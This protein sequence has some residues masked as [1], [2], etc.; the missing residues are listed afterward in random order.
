M[1]S[2]L[3]KYATN[4]EVYSVGSTGLIGKSVSV[5]LDDDVEAVRFFFLLN[6]I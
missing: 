6:V 3:K 4:E 1:V 5:D 2:S